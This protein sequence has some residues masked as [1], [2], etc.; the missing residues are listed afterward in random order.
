M[1]LAE[2]YTH[3]IQDGNMLSKFDIPSEHA[4]VRQNRM[5]YGHIDCIDNCALYDLL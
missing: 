5:K 1:K 4:M 2:Y 3:F